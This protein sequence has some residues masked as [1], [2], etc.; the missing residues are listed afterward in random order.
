MYLFFNYI[1]HIHQLIALFEYKVWSKICKEFTFMFDISLRYRG[2]A[3]IIRIP[4]SDSW[5]SNVCVT[6]VSVIVWHWS[7][8]YSWDGGTPRWDL[9]RHCVCFS[10]SASLLFLVVARELASFVQPGMR[11]RSAY[12]PFAAIPFAFD[13]LSLDVCLSVL[14]S[15]F[16]PFPLLNPFGKA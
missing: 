9:A 6:F 16:F 4:K 13:H 10:T 3:K 5:K 14:A 15:F 11:P 12:T 8:S 1:L 2:K 7:Q